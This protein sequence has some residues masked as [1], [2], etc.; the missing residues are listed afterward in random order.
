M[1]A[2]EVRE[3][4][5]NP[6]AARLRSEVLGQ[7][8]EVLHRV[9]REGASQVGGPD[10]AMLEALVSLTDRPAVRIENDRI[11]RNH[12]E[13]G[14]W[15]DTYALSEAEINATFLSVGRID[16]D[17]D[18]IGTGF[19]VKEGIIMTNRHVIEEFAAPIPRR[20]DPTGWVLQSNNVTIDFSDDARGGPTSFRVKSVIGA[21][22]QPIVDL[23][24][25]FT[26][27]DMALLEVETTNAAGKALPSP[28][29]LQGNPD[30]VKRSS[31]IFTVGYPAKPRVLP[32]DASGAIRMDVV[33]RLRT[34]YGSRYGVKYFS[35]GMVST[36]LGQVEGDGKGWVF[37]HDATT[38]GGNSGSAAFD[39]DEAIAIVGLH[40]AGD[41][42]RANHAHAVAAVKASHE[43]PRVDGFD[44]I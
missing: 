43:L 14:P 19:V 5:S 36:V 25:E 18:H 29:Q 16:A 40:F 37:N 26:K 12:P 7:G 41:W 24:V 11:D 17:G 6:L 13:L 42:L 15:K 31:R 27:L 21:G 9:M 39:L 1:R 28:L 34:I 3:G 8:E 23:P 10:R 38:L 30:R 22:R 33:T 20:T 2:I 32:R 35:P 4:G 44:W